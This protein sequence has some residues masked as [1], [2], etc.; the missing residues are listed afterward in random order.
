MDD[1]MALTAR[2]LAARGAAIGIEYANRAAEVEAAADE[3]E[4]PVRV[5]VGVLIGR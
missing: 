4:G 2:T 3:I 5:I 1:C